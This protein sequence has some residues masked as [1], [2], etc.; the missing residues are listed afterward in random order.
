[1]RLEPGCPRCASAVTG[2]GSAWL[3]ATHEAIVPLWRATDADYDAFAQYLVMSRPLPTWLPWPLPDGWHVT[4]FGAVGVEGATSQAAFVTCTGPSALDGA[5][6]LTVITEE[7]GVGLA[8]R[9]GGVRHS[10]PGREAGEG[11]PPTRI[12]VDGA[13]VPMWLVSTDEDAGALD[14]A[15]LAGEARGRWLWL[16]LRPGSAAL[17]LGELGPLHDVSELGPQLVTLPFGQVPRSW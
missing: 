8:A 3:C 2:T 13:T 12:R 4:D 1:M 7:P 10:D 14:R 16:V 5:V 17:S 6:E 11:T 15:V 9:C